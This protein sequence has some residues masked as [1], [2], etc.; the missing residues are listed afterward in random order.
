[1]LYSLDET[2]ILFKVEYILITTTKAQNAWSPLFS[3][4]RVLD[5]LFHSIS[6]F[7]TCQPCSSHMSILTLLSYVLENNSSY[8]LLNL[9]H[10]PFIVWSSIHNSI[11]VHYH[12]ILVPCSTRMDNS[13]PAYNLLLQSYPSPTLESQESVLTNPFFARRL[14]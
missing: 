10:R 11:I 2:M 4:H 1:M 6:E 13:N 12:V 14:S 7:P 3:L 5:E 9:T 8:C